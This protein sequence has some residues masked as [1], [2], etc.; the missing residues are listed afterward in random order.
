M[1]ALNEYIS[2]ERL[3]DAIEDVS[4][5]M[6]N[7]GKDVVPPILKEK[8]ITVIAA[9]QRNNRIHSIEM[10][11]AGKGGVVKA[12]LDPLDMQVSSTI[13]QNLYILRAE[14][15]DLHKNEDVDGGARGTK[16]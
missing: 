7:E 3:W 1:A 15:Q 16:H 8:M 12:Y 9:T 2:D 14:M 13:L 6:E 11:T 10:G 4:H 5:W